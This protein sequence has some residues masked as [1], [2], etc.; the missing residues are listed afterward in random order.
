MPL[1]LN[2]GVYVGGA[3]Q[4]LGGVRLWPVG[5]SYTMHTLI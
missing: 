1:N 4:T 5:M 2:W 3:F